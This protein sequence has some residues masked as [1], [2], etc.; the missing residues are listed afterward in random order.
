MSRFLI[1]LLCA[2][3]CLGVRARGDEALP[4][5]ID[6]LPHEILSGPQSHGHVQ[7]I[8]VDTENKAVYFSFTTFL[9]KTD[10]DGN[11]VGSVNGLT[12][13]LGCLTFDRG[14]NRIYGSLEYK[15]D[16]IGKGI[17]RNT[18]HEGAT[19]R[20]GFYIAIF[21][22]SKIDRMD[23]DA[24]AD[25]VMTTVYLRE[26]VD[27]YLAT[28]DA[29]G[30]TVEH[31]WGC[32]GID[33]V[34]F[35]PAPGSKNRDK[36]FLHVAY[37]I[38]ADTT[39]TD[40]DH[41]VILAYDTRDWRRYET[42]L[43]QSRPHT[44]GPRKPAHKYFVYTGNTTYGIQNLAYDPHSGDWFAAVYKGVKPAMPNYDLFVVDG[45]TKAVKKNIAGSYETCKGE[46]LS[47]KD[48]GLLDETTGLRGWRFRYGATG[49]CPIGGG[50][51][52]IS[53]N[54]KID[55]R[56]AS[57]LR[58]YRWTGDASSPFEEVE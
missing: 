35:A 27:D 39:R 46:Q 19:N 54:Y 48:A 22:A 34:T 18:S 47:L 50:Y 4:F 53:Q 43:N 16:A 32:S 58:L 29:G 6:S 24:E 2:F 7:G 23:M 15:N 13:H 49:I 21:D 57:R 28:V 25:S 8:V 51:F 9:L 5:S 26:V 52:Y 1:L 14:A 3:L 20:D 17:L 31:R 33:G 40:N 56:Q 38:Y 45:S 10:F 44:N 12:G 37:G 42:P 55:R 36:L 11:P 41:Q 30:R